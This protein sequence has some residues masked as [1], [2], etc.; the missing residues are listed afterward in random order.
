VA[1]RA[2]AISDDLREEINKSLEEQYGHEAVR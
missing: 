2:R 1:K